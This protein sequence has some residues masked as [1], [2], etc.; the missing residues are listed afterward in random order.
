[1]VFSVVLLEGLQQKIVVKSDWIDYSNN[2]QLLNNGVT[3]YEK[4]KIFYSSE[5]KNANWQLPISNNFDPSIDACYE[6]YVLRSFGKILRST[7]FF[8]E[9]QDLI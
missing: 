5:D 6:G 4:Q 7:Y 2:A 1:M 8:R 3:R 9:K